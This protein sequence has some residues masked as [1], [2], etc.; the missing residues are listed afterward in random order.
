MAYIWEIT[1]PYF[2]ARLINNVANI[3]INNPRDNGFSMTWEDIV[4]NN[5]QS[6]KLSN[7][8]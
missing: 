3:R 2:R 1:K 5:N 8:T 4:Q 6:Q 7:N